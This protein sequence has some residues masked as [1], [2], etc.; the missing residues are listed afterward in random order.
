MNAS[1]DT[2]RE[3][4]VSVRGMPTYTLCQGDKKHCNTII[5]IIPGLYHC[6]FLII[7]IW[8]LCLEGKS[9]D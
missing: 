6:V 1:K 4:W 9:K 8:I 5:I 7:Q 3:K 2:L